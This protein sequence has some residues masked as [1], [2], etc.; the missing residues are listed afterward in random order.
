VPLGFLIHMK[1]FSIFTAQSV[2]LTSIPRVVRESSSF[3]E[4][5]KTRASSS[6]KTTASELP[7]DCLQGIWNRFNE[8]C[9]EV[10]SESKLGFVVFQF[11]LSFKPCEESKLHVLEC[12]KKL[13]ARFDMAVEFRDRW[14]VLKDGE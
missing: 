14:E 3:I 6:Q 10:F 11:Q 13:D 12:R 1:A 2:P 5:N 4:F 9:L 8:V 7:P